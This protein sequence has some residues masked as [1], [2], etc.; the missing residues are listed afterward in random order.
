MLRTIRTL[1]HTLMYTCSEVQQFV[2]IDRYNVVFKRNI[3]LA[4]A[5]SFEALHSGCGELLTSS[6]HGDLCCSFDGLKEK[7]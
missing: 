3:N 2:S 5:C 6:V 1:V 4:S 7:M